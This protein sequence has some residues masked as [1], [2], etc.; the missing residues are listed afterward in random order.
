MNTRS[1]YTSCWQLVTM[2]F[3]PNACC[4][5]CHEDE[6]YGYDLSEKQL[7]CGCVIAVCCTHYDARQ[8]LLDDTERLDLLMQQLHTYHER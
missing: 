3:L 8:N 5:S 6:A 1:Y 7:P 2:G 4:G